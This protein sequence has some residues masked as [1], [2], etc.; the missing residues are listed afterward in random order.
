MYCLMVVGMERL[1]YVYDLL[2]GSWESLYPGG[3]FPY[4]EIVLAR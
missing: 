2:K 3:G 4:S 1:I